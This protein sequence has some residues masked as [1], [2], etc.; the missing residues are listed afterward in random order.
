M[1]TLFEVGYGEAYVPSWYSIWAPAGT[2]KEIIDKLNAK[3]V[4]IAG[5]PEMKARLLAM[6]VSC[7]PQSPEEMGR[8]LVEDTKRVAELIRLTNLKL[9]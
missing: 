1:P 9:E 5:T 4:E 8:H 7:P 2:P 6:N 3:M